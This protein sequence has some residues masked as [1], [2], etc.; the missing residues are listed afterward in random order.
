M[1]PFPSGVCEPV[2]VHRSPALVGLSLCL[3]G[4]LGV[5]ACSGRDK[6]VLAAAS[7]ATSTTLAAVAD[8]GA[9]TTLAPAAGAT[10]STTKA[11]PATSSTIAYFTVPS[12]TTEAPGSG[13]SFP[14]GESVGRRF[15]DAVM[16]GQ[17]SAATPLAGQ[18]VIDQFEPWKPYS[19]SNDQGVSVPGYRYSGGT[20]KGAF[21][22]TLKPTVFVHCTVDKGKVTACSFGE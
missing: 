7:D 18:A 5:A 2:G 6:K 13:G 4:A 22:A 19:R 15:I 12:S 16:D 21:D 20:T 3:A 10:T 8:P 1:R 14:P 11:A 9:T 17:R